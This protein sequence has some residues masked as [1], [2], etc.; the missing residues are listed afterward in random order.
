MKKIYLLFFLPALLF[1]SCKEE[2]NAVEEYANWKEVNEVAFKAKYSAAIASTNDNIDTIRCYS[3]TS[4]TTTD[5]SDY[6]VVQKLDRVE[7]L[8]KPNSPTGSPIFTDSVAV[9]YRG[10]LQPS[11]SYSQGLVFDQSFTSTS[12]SSQVA[13]PTKFITSGVVAGFCTALQK[14]KIG[15]HWMVYI[16]QELAYGSSTSNS[17]IPAYS[18]LTFEIVL[19]KYW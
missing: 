9:S 2:D 3:L 16:P 19:E 11:A 8:V 13:K 12:Y 14:M 17:S 6:I 5:P 10:R 18:M 4:K 7:E 15:D 1:C